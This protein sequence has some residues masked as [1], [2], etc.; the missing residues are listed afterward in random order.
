MP[1]LSYESNLRLIKLKSFLMAG[2]VRL[3]PDISSS[4]LFLGY[5]GYSGFMSFSEVWYLR[6]TEVIQVI[7]LGLS[8]IFSALSKPLDYGD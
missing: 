2:Q 3:A 6:V 5:R 4:K 8:P 1:L 7:G